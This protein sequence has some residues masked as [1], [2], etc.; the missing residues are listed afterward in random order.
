MLL[1]YEK[2]LYDDIKKAIDSDKKLAKTF[3]RAIGKSAL[4]IT[5]EDKNIFDKDNTTYETNMVEFPNNTHIYICLDSDGD[6]LISEGEW[7]NS[8]KQINLTGFLG[9][10]KTMFREIADKLISHYTEDPNSFE[11]VKNGKSILRYKIMSDKMSTLSQI[12]KTNNSISAIFKRHKDISY[13]DQDIELRSIYQALGKQIWYLYIGTDIDYNKIKRYLWQID[14]DY[15]LTLEFMPT[16]M[17]SLKLLKAYNDSIKN[18]LKTGNYNNYIKNLI[19]DEETFVIDYKKQ[20]PLRNFSIENLIYIRGC[21]TY[22]NI[23]GLLKFSRAK[24]ISNIVQKFSELL[25]DRSVK[26]YSESWTIESLRSN[27]NDIRDP[28]YNSP[29]LYMRYLKDNSIEFEYQEKDVKETVKI[30]SIE[31]LLKLFNQ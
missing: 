2:E 31:A 30:T 28:E 24:D 13:V 11:K 4:Y 29:V 5:I 10:F 23:Q 3:F 25:Y 8:D 18:Y 12:L 27:Y 26:G 22:G 15:S 16:G 19:I 21:G 9:D 14:S 7:D 1:D 6:L 17:L 20:L